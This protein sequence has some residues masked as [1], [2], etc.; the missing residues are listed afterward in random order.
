MTAEQKK[1]NADRMRARRAELRNDPKSHA[2]EREKERERY[3]KR[4]E[5]GKI[6]LVGDM[7][8]KEKQNFRKMKRNHARKARAEKKKIPTPSK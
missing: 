4:K 2:I 1:A 5:A 7:S 6:K 3:W 8:Y